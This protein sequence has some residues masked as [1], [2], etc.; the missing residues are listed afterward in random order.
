MKKLLLGSAAT[1]ALMTM[2]ANAADLPVKAPPPPPAPAWSW[3][4]WYIGAHVGGAW[5]QTT[6]SDPFGPSIF[7]DKVNTP[8]FLGGGQIGYNWQS[9]NSPWVFGVEADISGLD[10]DGTNTCFAFSGQFV[11]ANCH[12]SPEAL[13]TFTGRVGYATGTDGRTLLYLKGGAAWVHDSI[14]MTTAGGNLGGPLVSTISKTSW[15]GTV[16]AGIEQALTPAWSLSLEYDYMGFGSFS[17]ATPVGLKGID[18]TGFFFFTPPGATSVKQNVQVVKVGLNYRIGADA[19]ANWFSPAPS[20]PE[21]GFFKAPPA[22]GWAAGW[23]V[24]AGGRYWYSWSRFQKDLGQFVSSGGPFSPVSRLTY[25]GMHSNNGEFFAR[26][27]SPWNWFIKGFIGGGQIYNGHMNDEDFILEGVIPYSNTISGAVN[28]PDWYGAVDGGYDVL[29]GPGYKVG[30]FAGYFRFHETMNAFGCVQIA[31]LNS[32]CVGADAEPTSHLGITEDDTWQA[33]RLGISG[34]TMLLDR[35]KLSGEVAYLPYVQFNGIDTHL[36][37]GIQFPESSN[38]GRGV[39]L[40]AILSY[41]LTPQFSVGV[42]GR[43]WALWT[44]TGQFNCIASPLTCDGAAFVTNTQPQLF[45]GAVEQSGVFVQASYKFG[46][47]PP[48]AAKD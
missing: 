16:G 3:T 29:R 43:Y 47:I 31:N 48:I 26:V 9:A 35:V 17:A 44:K 41:Y 38:N 20:Y 42:G 27:D 25:D 33:L 40:E 23:D 46:A 18:T 28:G 24:E 37:R 7:G 13:G 1:L 36:D 34:E 14:D 10:S 32:D 12:V 30:P 2:A 19:W 39:Q 15:G 6:F 5:G 11:P 45:R 4:G 21:A 8:G 22:P